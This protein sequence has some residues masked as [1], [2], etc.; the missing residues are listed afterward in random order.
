[1]CFYVSSLV[2]QAFEPSGLL[3]RLPPTPSMDISPPP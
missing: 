2:F 1:M 3:P